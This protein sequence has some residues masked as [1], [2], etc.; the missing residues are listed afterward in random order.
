MRPKHL[1][2][3]LAAV[4]TVLPYAEFLRFVA[5]EGLD[6]RVMVE[7]LFGSHASAFFTLDVIVTTVVLWVFVA[8]ERRRHA[9]P[10]AWA[11]VAASLVVGVSLGLPLLLYLRETQ[12][13]STGTRS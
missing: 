6:L 4:G 10:H 1:Y 11:P 3:A 8:V 13:N 5:A 7:Q 2:L 9:L 12:V